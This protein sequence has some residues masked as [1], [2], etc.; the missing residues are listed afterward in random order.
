MDRIIGLDERKELQLSMLKEID[1]FC[2]KNNIRYSLAFGTLLGAIRH[3]GFI[4]W[5]DD[6]D[7]MMPL[8]DMRKFKSIFHS[9]N[10]K[11]C[12]VDTESYYELDFPRIAHKSTYKFEGRGVKSYGIS[13]DLYVCIPLPDDE[14]AFFTKLEVLEKRRK[15]MIKLRRKIIR[16]LPISTI[17]GFKS[18]VKAVNRLEFTKRNIGRKGLYYMVAAP[19]SIRNKNTYDRDIFSEIQYTKF[20]DGVFPII[21]DYH[22]FLTKMYGDYMQLPPEDKRHPYHNATFY[23]K[24]YDK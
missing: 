19:L 16:Y 2:K 10:L 20:E 12:D 24:S 15:Q 1:E 3:S 7:I 4:P 9:E 5:D 14:D 13:I 22:Y 21:S 18:A 23:W 8:D 11:F 17:P 6:L